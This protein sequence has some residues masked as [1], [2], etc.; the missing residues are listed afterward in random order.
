MKQYIIL[1]AFLLFGIVGTAHA[2]LDGIGLRTQLPQWA[3]LSPG[4]GFDLSWNGRYMFTAF[5]SYGDWDISKDTK[6]IRISTAGV[7]VRRYFSNGTA[8]WLNPSGGQY[9]GMYL[10]LAGRLLNFDSRL[11]SK[12]KQ[13]NIWTVGP[14]LGYTFHLR[15]NWT[16]DASF[17]LGYCYDDYS[18]YKWY[19]PMEIYRQT[20]Q[21]SG[22]RFGLTDVSIAITYRFK[23]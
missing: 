19:P 22:G 20:K 5:G 13:G 8:S 18:R 14:I 11:T 23:L 1:L 3:F 7:D 6:T 4:A 2:Q 15:G 16:C 12:S 21:V 10:G 17:G 9:F